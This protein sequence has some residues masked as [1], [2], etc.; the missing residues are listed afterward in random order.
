MIKVF[1]RGVMTLFPEGTRMRTHKVGPGRVGAGL[2]ML[3]AQPKVIPVA[4]DGMDELL[5]IGAWW[6]RMFKHIYVYYGEPLDYSDYL[7]MPRTKQTSQDLVDRAMDRVRD[8]YAA[9]R[10]LR[11]KT[12]D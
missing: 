5:P 9:L 3:S 7:N 12:V 8:Q 6:P 11:G 10:R 2:I 1:P 4:I